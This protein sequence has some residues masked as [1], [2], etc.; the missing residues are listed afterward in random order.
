MKRRAIPLLSIIIGAL[1]LPLTALAAAGDLE[2]LPSSIQFAPQPV[3]EGRKTRI[4]ATV[5]SNSKDDLYGTVRFTNQSEGKQI[6][7]DQPISVFGGKTDDVFV[8]WTPQAGEQTILVAI[9]PWQS[10]DNS[11]NNTYKVT[12]NVIADLDHDGVSDSE[13]TDV[14]GDGISNSNDAFPRNPKE[15]KDTDGDGIGD[16]ADSDDDNDGVPDTQDAFPFD[17]KESKDTDGDGVGDNADPDIDGDGIPNDKEGQLG[18]NPVLKDTDGDKVPDKKDLFPKDIMESKDTNKNGVGDN[19]DPDIDGDGVP[20]A[21]DAFP[22]NRGPQ[23]GNSGTPLIVQVGNGNTLLLDATPSI[24][25][26][27]K[28]SKVV[29]K[30]D[31]QKVYEGVRRE[32][33]IT[34]TGTHEIE[35]QVTDNNGETVAKKWNFYG[36]ASV[37]LAQGGWLVTAIALALIGL[38]YYSTRA[39]KRDSKLKSDDDHGKQS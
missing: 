30:I 21:Q 7:T 5:K 23:A 20:N 3:T 1:I 14:D 34:E 29:W 32:V 28:I 27:G 13:D 36:T 10:G 26:D 25:P 33:P 24:D 19:K 15:S 12:I 22:N 11:G 9:M 37:L 18:T 6:G 17:P 16:N 4:Y 2:L 39:R 31:N 8:D 38:F 35:L